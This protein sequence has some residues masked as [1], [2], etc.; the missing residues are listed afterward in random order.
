MPVVIPQDLPAKKTLEDENIFVMGK[1]RAEH[2]DIRPLEIVILNLMPTKIET[3]TQFARLLGNTPLQINL[4][5]LTTASYAPKNTSKDHMNS[6]YK[7]WEEVQDKQFD[8]CI[9]TGAPVE[10]LPFSEVQYWD[11]L[12][13]IL[14]WSKDHVFAS[15]YVCWAAQAA[16]HRFYGIEKQ[17]LQEKK[18]GVFDARIVT[19]HTKLLRGFDDAFCV[20]VSRHTAIDTAGIEEQ[21]DLQILAETDDGDPYILQHTSLRQTYYFNH[22]EYDAHSLHD[23]YVRDVEKGSEIAMPQKYYP[24][25]DPKKPPMRRWHAH[26]NL[27]YSN[28]INYCVYQETPFDRA[29]IHN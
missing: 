6:F 28:W 20:P 1:S 17:P 26:A 19:P 3:E 29:E 7:T 25:D 18:F 12:T 16:L 27:L 11:E 24:E 4:T 13:Q 14:D 22:P 8:G 10:H 9:V 23:E 15:L 2:Q 21:K 5:L